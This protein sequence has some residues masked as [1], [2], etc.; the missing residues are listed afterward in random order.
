MTKPEDKTTSSQR[1]QGIRALMGRMH[2]PLRLIATEEPSRIGRLVSKSICLLL[3][4]M[5]VWSVVGKLDIIVSASGKLVPQTLVKI[6]QPAEQGIVHE[7]LVD[8]G[9]EVSEGQLLVRLDMTLAQADKASISG[10]LARQKMQERRIMAELSDKPMVTKTDDDPLLFA[11]VQSQYSAHRRAFLDNVAQEQSMLSKAENERRSA[12]K[13]LSKME[14]TLPV[15][16]ES[17]RA[18]SELQSKGFFSPLATAEKTK[19]CLERKKD[20]EAQ[21]LSIASLGDM[22]AAQTRKIAQLK[23]YYHS[24]LERELAQVRTEIVRLEPTLDKTLYREGLM[25]L[26]APQAGII[27]YLSTTTMGAVVQPGSVLM[28]LVPKDEPL[29]ADVS[30]RNE[31]VGFVQT[32][33]KVQIKLSAYPFQKYGLVSGQVIRLSADSDDGSDVKNSKDQSSSYAN[34]LPYRARI[35]LDKQYLTDPNGEQLH[36][37]AGMQVVAEI[38]Q[39]R[40]TVLEYLL[41]PVQ[42]VF[43]EAARER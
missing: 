6:V 9:D 30:I 19:E 15:Y 24:E 23:S 37:S 36:L 11:Q 21:K 17:A 29:Y 13:V 43:H 10:E 2:D 27:K 33:Q 39:G 26:R 22:I 14:Q 40:R 12:Q 18:Y 28:T 35:R 41:S 1:W 4:V 31:D 25:E 32:G 8:E 5:L 34:L 7:L 42:K 20:I 16:E 3:L 38:N